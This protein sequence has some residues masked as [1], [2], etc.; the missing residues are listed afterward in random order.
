M[1]ETT[2]SRMLSVSVAFFVFG[3][4]DNF[5]MV[6]FGDQIDAGFQAVGISN[7]MLAAGLG[8]TL[9]DAIGILSG[10]Y[11]ELLVHR[12]IP[13][14]AE[15]VLSTPQILTAEGLGIIAGCLVGL[16]PLLWL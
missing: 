13:K 8:N 5:L 1:L 10:R 9:S 11:V 16:F 4:I 14:V 15:G 3:F 12:R 7:T 6:I 2:L